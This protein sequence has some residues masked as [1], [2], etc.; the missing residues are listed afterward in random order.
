LI[1]EDAELEAIEIESAHTIEI[2]SFVP[3]SGIDRRY[4]T[5]LIM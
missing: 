2:D 5:A 3:R 1:I 4:S